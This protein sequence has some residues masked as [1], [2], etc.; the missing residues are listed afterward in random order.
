MNSLNVIQA[1][2]HT[3]PNSKLTHMYMYGKKERELL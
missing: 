2:I 3:T 1:E